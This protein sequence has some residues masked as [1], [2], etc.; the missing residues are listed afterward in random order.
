MSGFGGGR[1]S[2]HGRV[3][4]IERQVE[5]FVVSDSV[6]NDRIKLVEYPLEIAEIEGVERDPSPVL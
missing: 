1:G 6:H 4:N 5:N 2:L 3:Q